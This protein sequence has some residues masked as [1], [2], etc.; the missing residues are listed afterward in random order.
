MSF[1]IETLDKEKN[2]DLITIYDERSKI[3][4][5]NFG[6]RIVDWKIDVDP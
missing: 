2:I 5:T 4:F 3:Q 1:E 6:L